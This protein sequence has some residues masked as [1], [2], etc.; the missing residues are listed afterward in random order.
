M[1]TPAVLNFAN[2]A[3]NFF[4]PHCH[5]FYKHSARARQLLRFINAQMGIIVKLYGGLVL[6]LRIIQ[7]KCC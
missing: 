3:E 1:K 2:F 7:N 5:L 4:I 6:T